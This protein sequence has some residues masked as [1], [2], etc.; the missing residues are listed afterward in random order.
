MR[1]SSGKDAYVPE[2][3]VLETPE[4][5]P[6]EPV[7][8]SASRKLILKMREV[9]PRWF[10]LCVGLLLLLAGLIQYARLGRTIDRRLAE[11]PFSASADILTAP[12]TLS[13]GEPVTALDVARSLRLSGYSQS[14]G[15][16]AGRF[17]EQTDAIQIWPGTNSTSGGDTVRVEFAKDRISAIV[18][19]TDRKPRQEYRLDP[20]LVANLS[21]TR[22]RRRLVRF[23]D[24]PPSLVHAV[25][26]VE[27]K[28]FFNHTGFDLPRM[29]K[30]AY[31]DL[32][33]GRKREGAST[34]TMQLARSLWLDRTKS[35]RRKAEEIFITMH[36][37][38]KLTKQQI[39]EDYS[40]EVYLGQRGAFSINGF[41]EGA[42]VLFGKDLSQVDTAQAALLAGLVQMPSAYNPIQYPE[43]ARD[44]RNLVLS[45]MRRNGYLN[46]TEY[47]DAAASP[48]RIAPE[49]G[50]ESAS[51]YFVALL[52]EEL[53]T[54]LGENSGLSRYVYTTLDPDLQLAAETAV[55]MGM[56]N[57]DQQLRKRGGEI[58][59]GQ[60]QVALIALDPRT[61]EI[62]A[63]VGGRDYGASQ[64]NHVLAMRQPGSVF[65]PFVYAAAMATAVEG[66]PKIFT[67]ASMLHD[68]TT[69]FANGADAYQ[70]RDFHG[71]FMGDITV[72]TA[73]AHSLN[74]PA[75]S[76]AQQVGFQKVV[77]MARRA[78]LNDS[79]KPTPSVALGAYEATPLEIAAAYTM[80]A[81]QGLRVTPTTLSL[82]ERRDGTVLYRH[83]TDASPE[84]DPR[85][86]YLMVNLMQE[87]LRS[88]TGAAV[89]S[90]GFALPA[91]GKTG[92]SRDGW[93]AGFTSELLCVVWVGYDDNRDLHL[94]GARSA[95][96]IW[97]A[98]MKRASQIRPYSNAHE[99]KP[100]SGIV[101]ANICTGTGSL[102]GAYCPNVRSEVFIAGT[103]PATECDMHNHDQADEET[104]SY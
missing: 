17:D 23:G 88:G 104:P 8:I 71:D 27:D 19:L 52:N 44:R 13:V 5:E 90:K 67:P 51:G 11:G 10:S 73:L 54:K 1:V 100:P 81:N 26:S 65:K 34:L 92:T 36:L 60:P 47:R 55:R 29:L 99:F 89:R 79:I 91:A 12:R 59:P 72:R 64:L 39:F 16:P 78:G 53:R 25:I 102:A 84:L 43:R 77:D 28:H 66:G 56:E 32:K 49:S 15:N 80:F 4:L 48:I 22:E 87:V 98:F 101:S 86:A 31:V 58:P 42:R 95:L 103:E 30:S 83:Q 45:L 7:R 57:V 96:P 2:K 38:H 40:N 68:E 18:S 20:Q 3:P 61:G 94:E 33:D 50:G 14:R 6:L 63:L 24:L 74:V 41:G 62:K 21:Q 82:V 46:E 37:E 97:T 93:F 70:P 69:A 85:V 35:W 9:D 75:V 76:L